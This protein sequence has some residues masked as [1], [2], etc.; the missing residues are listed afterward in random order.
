VHGAGTRAAH[1][2]DRVAEQ[3]QPLEP[4]AAGQF[5]ERHHRRRDVEASRRDEVGTVA[6][7][8]RR[9]PGAAI[10]PIKGD[11]AAVPAGGAHLGPG[12][13]RPRGDVRPSRPGRTCDEHSDAA[14]DAS[15]GPA[16]PLDAPGA[17]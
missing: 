9:R 1:R 14:H 8:Q 17:Q 16:G 3:H 12:R 15:V 11:V 13:A 10:V 2:E 4:V 7:V 6:A 5:D